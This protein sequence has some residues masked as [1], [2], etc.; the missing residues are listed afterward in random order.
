MTLTV[1]LHLL[2]SPV[3]CESILLWHS[4]VT[5]KIIQ[6]ACDTPSNNAPGTPRSY[7]CGLSTASPVMVFRLSMKYSTDNPV[8]CVTTTCNGVKMLKDGV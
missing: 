4:E 8:L 7:P 3:T 2:I 5:R 1:V 6:Q